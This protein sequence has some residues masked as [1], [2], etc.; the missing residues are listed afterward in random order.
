[1]RIQALAATLILALVVACEAPE[2]APPVTD[3][4]A[5]AAAPAE[6]TLPD[7]IEVDEASE[8]VSIHLTAGATP[9]NNYWNFQGHFGGTGEVVVPAGYTVEMTLDNQDPAMAHSVG[10]GE[11]LPSYPNQFPEVEPIFEGAVTSNPRSLTESTLPGEQET[12]TFVA[13]QAGE[14]ALICYVTGHAAS[15][16]WMPFTVSAE[17][18]VGVIE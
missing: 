1:M 9:G 18:E 4:P 6:L 15:G 14:Y 5:P 10:V 8:M 13:D 16:M 11:L 2:E 3:E 17:G 12:I 7:W